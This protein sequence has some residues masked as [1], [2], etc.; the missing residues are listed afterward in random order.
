MKNKERISANEINRFSY[1]PYQWYYKRTYGNAELTKRYKA[2]KLDTSQHESF[3]TKGT[4][5]HTFYYHKYK[6]VRILQ[7]GLGILLV[8]YIMKMVMGG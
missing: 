8:G 6:C 1:C 7:I 4:K 5:H 3:Y 2:L